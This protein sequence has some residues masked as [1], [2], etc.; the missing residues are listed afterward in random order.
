[1]MNLFHWRREMMQHIEIDGVFGL[2]GKW[3]CDVYNLSPNL[4]T[5]RNTKSFNGLSPFFN[6][7]RK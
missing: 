2:N 7:I 1:M 5:G 3:V 6:L 4:S